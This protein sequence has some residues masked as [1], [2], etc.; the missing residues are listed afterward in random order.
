MASAE[1]VL[2]TILIVDD[3]PGN[4]LSLEAVLSPLGYPLV[5]ASSGAEALTTALK[6]ELAMIVMNVH[7]PGLDGYETMAQLRER[8]RL[9]DVPVIFLTAV[10]GEP[11][12]RHRGYALGAIDYISKPFDPQVLRAKVGALVPLYL[13]GQ[14]AER[15]RSVEKDRMKDLF[16]GAVGHDLR[17]PLN[18]IALA[19]KVLG[20]HS[21]GPPSAGMRS[22]SSAPF[23]AWTG[24]SRTSSTSREVSSPAESR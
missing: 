13:R 3:H 21:T 24:S 5:S 14:R 8:E 23:A 12:H 11:E 6:E 18:T 16:L 9:R 7:M 2:P 22:E 19:A 10:Y 20:G 15:L 4:L 17:N 1:S